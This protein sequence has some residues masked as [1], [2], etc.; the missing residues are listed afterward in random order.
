MNLASGQAGLFHVLRLSPGTDLRNA[1]LEW[2]V[3]EGIEAAYVAS[4]VGSLGPAVLRHAGHAKGLQ[5]SGDLELLSLHGTLSRHGLHLHA[6]VGDADG[7]VTGGHVMQGC[8]VRTTVEAVLH[9]LE[10]V[11]MLRRTD[12]TT[13]HLEL[14]PVR[15]EDPR[16]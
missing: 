7:R 13:G 14:L 1:L 2:C 12:P 4:A 11:R 8:V 15:I 6:M 16:Q 9:T 3:E 5:L 10:G